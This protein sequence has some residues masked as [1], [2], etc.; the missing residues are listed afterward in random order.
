MDYLPDRPIEAEQEDK[1]NRL[2]FA[3]RIANTIA[4]RT[5]SSSLVVGIFGKWGE[6][7][8]S[9]LN[10]MKSALKHHDD[11]EVVPFNPWHFTSQEGQSVSTAGLNVV[12]DSIESVSV[13]PRR[14]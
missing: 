6:G 9:V 13:R 14:G 1:F 8:T 2:P 10:L 3:S 7:K 5:D 4:H 11:V 12:S